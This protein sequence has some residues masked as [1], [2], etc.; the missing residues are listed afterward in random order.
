MLFHDVQRLDL[1]ITVLERGSLE[2]QKTVDGVCELK[3]YEN[4]IIYIVP[5]GSSVKQGEVVVRFDSAEIDKEIAQQ[6]INVNQARGKVDTTEQEL[7]IAKNQAE[8]D[9]AAAETELKLATL[10]LRKYTLGDY[11]VQLQD[12]QGKIALAEFELSKAKVEFENFKTLV[13]KGFREPEQL[14]G[15]EQNVNSAQFSLERD[16]RSLLVL[17]EYDH[18]RQKTEY[19][20]KAAEAERKLTRANANAKANIAKAQSELEAARATLKLEEQRLEEYLEQKTKCE[21]TAAQDGV[22]AY[23]NEDWYDS[24]RRIREG[25]VVYQRQKIFS[26][27]DLSMLQVKVNVHESVI[28][29]VNAGQSATIRVD[30]FPSDT[31]RGTVKTVSQLADSSSSWRRGGVKEYTT[32]VILDEAFDVDLKPGMT[33]EVSILVDE[34]Q[35]VV[36]IPVNA[37]AEHKHQHFVYLRNG[38]A[39]TRAPV[40]IG[41]SND[42]MIEVISG[43]D[44]Q[45]Q[46]ALDARARSIND[47]EEMLDELFPE[48]GDSQQVASTEDVASSEGGET[49]APSTSNDSVAS[50][51]G[52]PPPLETAEAS[53]PHDA[54]E[55]TADDAASLNPSDDDETESTETEKA[56]DTGAPNDSVETVITTAREAN[57]FSASEPSP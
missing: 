55:V 34:L 44:P 53:L 15:F 3:G 11:E 38:D 25:A 8:S 43:L 19:E 47:G 30:A 54:S 37:V 26:L 7:A 28:K 12:L 35:D 21:I 1:R 22:L 29:K 31:F 49:P 48:A 40:E 36:A 10:D 5:E 33:A 41:Q 13:K 42:R 27:P 52:E 39:L 4:K 14:R 9:V 6:E 18:V 50:D 20:A 45:G 51:S 16:K 2:S 32:V 23:A 57:T 56:F 17:Q 24:N 46:V